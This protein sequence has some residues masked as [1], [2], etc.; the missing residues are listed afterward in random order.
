MLLR[1]KHPMRIKNRASLR[2]L[3]LIHA[4]F[5]MRMFN[6]SRVIKTS[7]INNLRRMGLQAVFVLI[8]V[9][10]SN[11]KSDRLYGCFSSDMQP[12]IEPIALVD[13]VPACELNCLPKRRIS[14]NE[15]LHCLKSFVTKWHTIQQRRGGMIKILVVTLEDRVPTLYIESL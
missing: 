4:I 8:P 3:W 2:L 15:F 1:G 14:S 10:V 12:V 13:E 9:T 5:L 6:D 11:V 7:F